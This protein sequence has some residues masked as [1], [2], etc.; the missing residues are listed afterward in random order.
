MQ[1]TDSFS[2][3]QPLQFLLIKSNPTLLLQIKIKGLFSPC[4]L[5]LIPLESLH[6]IFH[7]PQNIY[8]LFIDRFLQ[9][10]IP[11]IC[12]AFVLM[13]FL[14]C[15][16]KKK[17]KKTVFSLSTK[18][19]DRVKSKTLHFAP[20][21]GKSTSNLNSQIFLSGIPQYEIST[22][23]QNQEKK[24]YFSYFMHNSF[25]DREPGISN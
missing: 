16:L 13:V 8:R 12:V 9:I 2:P 25:T 6:E 19:E 10:L 4:I 7:Q 1:L 5:L 17:R 23:Y 18:K 22:T 15:F 3:Y 20:Q 14:V 21:D 11:K 24:N